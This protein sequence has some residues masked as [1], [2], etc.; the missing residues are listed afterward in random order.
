MVRCTNTGFGCT[1]E[2]IG[3]NICCKY[4]DKISECIKDIDNENGYI[5]CGYILSTKDIKEECPF[6]EII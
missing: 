5:L 1:C 6:E 3:I 2:K 4:C